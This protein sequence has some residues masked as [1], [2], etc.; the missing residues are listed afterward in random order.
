MLLRASSRDQVT[1]PD[2]DLLKPTQASTPGAPH[3]AANPKHRPKHSQPPSQQASPPGRTVLPA[4]P[5]LLFGQPLPQPRGRSSGPALLQPCRTAALSGA[6][7]PVRRAGADAPRSETL[8]PGRRTGH[9]PPIADRSSRVCGRLLLLGAFFSDVQRLAGASASGVSGEGVCVVHRTSGGRS[10]PFVA[11][12]VVF[13][14][15]LALA[16]GRKLSLHRR[17]GGEHTPPEA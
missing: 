4:T 1:P 6:P 7:G 9:G 16:S 13:D 14:A 12:P 5:C 15:S 11:R 10:A 17:R 8:F 3:P 2:R